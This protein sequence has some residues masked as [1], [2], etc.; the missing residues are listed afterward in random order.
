M[1]ISFNCLFLVF[2]YLSLSRFFPSKRKPIEPIYFSFVVCACVSQRD[3]CRK[4]T[5]KEKGD[6]IPCMFVFFCLCVYGSRFH[7][8]LLFFFFFCELLLCS[9]LC[10]LF[11]FYAATITA[12]ATVFL[13]LFIKRLSVCVFVSFYYLLCVGVQFTHFILLFSVFSF[14]Y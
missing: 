5:R 1:S 7:C 11:F 4:Q 8:R 10:F 9:E 2:H 6:G 13:Y 3:L 12:A 14:V